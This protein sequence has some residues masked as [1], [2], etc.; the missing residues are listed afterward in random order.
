M[1]R[2]LKTSGLLKARGV[3]QALRQVEVEGLLNDWRQTLEE[4]NEQGILK[5]QDGFGNPMVPIAET[6][7]KYRKSAVGKAD[8]NAPPM[9]PCYALS[10]V[11]ANYVTAFYRDGVRWVVIGAWE[12][13]LSKKGVPFLPFHFRG[14]GHLPVRNLAHI[15][16]WGMQR[17][18]EQLAARV[19]VWLKRAKGGGP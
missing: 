11:I 1:A 10:R 17:A 4:D 18:R 13:V 8:P 6:T 2:E 15:R 14:E 9:I 12:N 16:P 3:L 19:K 5:G 7:K